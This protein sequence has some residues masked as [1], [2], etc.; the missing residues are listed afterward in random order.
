MAGISRSNELDHSSFADLQQNR[1][2]SLDVNA[3]PLPVLF[4]ATACLG[5]M[6]LCGATSLPYSK[7]RVH[8]MTV[9]VAVDTAVVVSVDAGEVVADVMAVAL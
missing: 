8:P 9:V 6:Q 3:S 1:P 7:C 2:T 4:P 5:P